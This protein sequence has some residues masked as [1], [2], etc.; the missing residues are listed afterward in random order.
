MEVHVL[1]R[2]T[3][4]GGG[5][6]PIA[7]HE[8]EDVLEG[9]HFD[10]AWVLWWNLA[11]ELIPRLRRLLPGARLV[12]DSVDVAYLR[13]L[14]QA[15]LNEVRDDWGLAAYTRRQEHL[16]YRMADRV[17]TVTDDD[18][19]IGLPDTPARVK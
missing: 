9:R 13:L 16:A 18:G 4:R 11:L 12:A 2:V 19:E 1:H 8:L 14:R 7:I 5:W 10:A 17:I 3:R 15:S 6:Y